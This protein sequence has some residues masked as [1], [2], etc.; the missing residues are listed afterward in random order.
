MLLSG[1]CSGDGALS[2]GILRPRGPSGDDW[3][4]VVEGLAAE[5]VPLGVSAEAGVTVNGT[6]VLIC[7]LLVV[8]GEC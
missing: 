6:A 1:S 2:K 7:F 8:Y 5:E 3:Y 4:D